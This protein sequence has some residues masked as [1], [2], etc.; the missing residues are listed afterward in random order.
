MINVDV[1]LP[2]EVEVERR[3]L[4][5]LEL[6]VVPRN[7]VNQIPL[8]AIKDGMN[9]SATK[10]MGKVATG[11]NNRCALIKILPQTDD[12]L[13]NFYYLLFTLSLDVL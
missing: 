4:T 13:E 12:A 9:S 1:N 2:L 5:H 8:Q 6:I 7:V 3:I 11:T 10:G